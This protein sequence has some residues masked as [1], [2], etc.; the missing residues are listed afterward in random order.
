MENKSFQSTHS[1]ESLMTY[2][3]NLILRRE[4]IQHQKEYITRRLKEN[5]PLL[6]IVV[7][8][9]CSILIGAIQIILQ[10]ILIVNKSPLYY[11]GHGIWG[12]FFTIMIGLLCIKFRIDFI[13]LI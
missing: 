3:E 6:Y 8:L 9:S 5:F 13:N 2:E 11:I 4:I 1:M 7:F 10:I 12:G